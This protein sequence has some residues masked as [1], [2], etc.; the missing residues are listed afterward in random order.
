M[1][2]GYVCC[3][4]EDENYGKTWRGMF[5]FAFWVFVIMVLASL[6][7]ILQPL[8]Q[9]FTQNYKYVPLPSIFCSQ[10]LFFILLIIL[11]SVRFN[12][13]GSHCGTDIELGDPFD[14]GEWE[15][16]EEQEERDSGNR[17]SENRD[18]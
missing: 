11:T 4:E 14:W 17:D 16:P 5:V 3:V 15:A 13:K 7:I 12:D 1:N 10:L 6:T 2:V 18:S 8:I 9:P